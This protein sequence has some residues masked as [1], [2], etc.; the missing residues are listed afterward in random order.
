MAID[1]VRELE[2]AW[3]I[4]GDQAA[5]DG[6]ADGAEPEQRDLAGA[7]MRGEWND[8]K[9]IQAHYSPSSPRSRCPEGI[10]T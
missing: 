5:R 9:G 8:V 6:G 3:G 2:T 7:R 1:D 4:R 10:G